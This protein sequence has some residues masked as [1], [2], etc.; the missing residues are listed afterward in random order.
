MRKTQILKVNHRL[1]NDATISEDTEISLLNADKN[2]ETIKINY[3]STKNQINHFIKI[4]KR[5]K[6]YQTKNSQ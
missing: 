2:S 5:I 6:I 4:R 1:K 3:K